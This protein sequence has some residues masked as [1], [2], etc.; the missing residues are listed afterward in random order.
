MPAPSA[1]LTP[2]LGGIVSLKVDLSG[3]RGRG[4]GIPKPLGGVGGSNLATPTLHP[5]LRTLGVMVPH[6]V[7]APARARCGTSHYF[8]FPSPH[9]LLPSFPTVP[10]SLTYYPITIY[11][12]FLSLADS[13]G[14]PAGWGPAPTSEIFQIHLRISLPPS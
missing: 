4:Y 9:T 12:L 8:I 10:N 5:Q 13:G 1:G 14:P 11:S 3:L 2:V 7:H 6:R